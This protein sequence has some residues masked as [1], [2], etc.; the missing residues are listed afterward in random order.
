MMLKNLRRQWRA[1]SREMW[2]CTIP[3]PLFRVN[4]PN[5]LVGLGWPTASKDELPALHPALS[6]GYAAHASLKSVIGLVPCD[7]EESNS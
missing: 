6:G 1:W 7:R 4:D 5:A 3:P 2:S